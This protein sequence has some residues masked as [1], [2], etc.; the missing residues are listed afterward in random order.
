M[1]GK[2]SS[3]KTKMKVVAIA[4]VAAIVSSAA[5]ADDRAFVVSEVPVYN[6][7]DIYETVE[8]CTKGD[9]KTTEGAIVGGLIGSQE[10]NAGLG[11]LLGAIIGDSIGEEKCTT[12]RRKVGTQQVYS[13]TILKVSVDGVIYTFTK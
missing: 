9:D 4:A 7:M 6:T 3:R 5:L 1:L 10:G 12:E 13:H 8:V 11:A 2:V